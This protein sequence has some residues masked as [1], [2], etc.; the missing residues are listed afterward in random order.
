MSEATEKEY[1]IC[2]IVDG[3]EHT[4]SVLN[5]WGPRQDWVSTS[6]DRRAEAERKLEEYRQY[7]SIL[8]SVHGVV[9]PE[10]IWIEERK[11]EP[12]RRI[13]DGA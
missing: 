7:R 4:I 8:S 10:D 12:W 9:R 3:L 11:V 1:R 2:A 5:C 6:E 13:G